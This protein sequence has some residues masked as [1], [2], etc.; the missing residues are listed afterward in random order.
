[1]LQYLLVRPYPSLRITFTSPALRIPGLAQS[2][3]LDRIGGPQHIRDGIFESLSQGI[4]VTAKVSWLHTATNPG[5]KRSSL[6]GKPRWIHCTPMLGSDE[7]VGVWMIVM[8]EK[9]E[10]TGALNSRTFDLPERAPPVADRLPESSS[11]SRHLE[12]PGS[13]HHENSSRHLKSLR[14]L[15][16]ELAGSRLYAEYLMQ[17]EGRSSRPMSPHSTQYGSLS[18]RRGDTSLRANNGNYIGEL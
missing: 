15:D 2:R 4:G 10:I 5:E 1:L 12:S 6:E 11:R 18:S 3:L 7:K 17:R 9:E 13:R 16:S 14:G 8:I